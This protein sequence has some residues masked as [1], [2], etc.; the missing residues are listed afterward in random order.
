MTARVADPVVHITLCQGGCSSCPHP[1]TGVIRQDAPYLL[2]NGKKAARKGDKGT[3]DCPHGGTFKIIQGSGNT[4]FQPPA[5][6]VN[7][8][9]QCEKCGAKGKIVAG[10]PNVFVNTR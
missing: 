1:W 5:A 4:T 2:I 10:S 6:R 8:Q 3:I 7:D 9:V